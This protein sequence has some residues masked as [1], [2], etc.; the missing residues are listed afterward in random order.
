MQYKIIQKL[1]ESIANKLQ[2]LNPGNQNHRKDIA[3]LAVQSNRQYRTFSTTTNNVP[4]DS[5]TILDAGVEMNRD[6]GTMILISSGPRW[7]A[8]NLPAKP[9]FC[10]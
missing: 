6:V 2:R 4:T 9:W 8:L 5:K 3:H 1:Q 7:A 10:E